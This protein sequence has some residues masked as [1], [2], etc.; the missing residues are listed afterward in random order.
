VVVYGR[1]PKGETIK[2]FLWVNSPED[3]HAAFE[4][5]HGQRY[6]IERWRVVK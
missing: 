4:K 6:K 2:S 5:K 3:V 1:S